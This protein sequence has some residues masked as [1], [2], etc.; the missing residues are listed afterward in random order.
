LPSQTAFWFT[1]GQGYDVD[2]LQWSQDFLQNLCSSALLL[3]V[4][5]KIKLLPP[6][7]CRGPMF[8][9]QM[10]SILLAMSRETG[11]AVEATVFEPIQCQRHQ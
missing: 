1:H 9:F 10:M 4:T 11:F 7:E 6:K 2:N 5:D 3:K 8:F